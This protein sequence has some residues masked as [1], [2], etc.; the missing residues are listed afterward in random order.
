MNAKE[1]ASVHQLIAEWEWSG[2]A[3]ASEAT[4]KASCAASLMSALN[5]TDEGLL[6]DRLWKMGSRLKQ[7]YS[8][9]YIGVGWPHDEKVRSRGFHWPEVEAEDMACRDAIDEI[10]DEV[11]YDAISN[12]IED[13]ADALMQDILKR[14]S[15]YVENHS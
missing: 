8:E 1:R 6:F 13:D 5:I 12:M 14:S 11:G 3:S 4:T 2:S 9:V 15:K 10:C 7:M